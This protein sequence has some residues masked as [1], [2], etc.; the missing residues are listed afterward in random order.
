MKLP[1]CLLAGINRHLG[2]PFML[3]VFVM[4]FGTSSMASAAIISNIMATKHNLSA[5]GPG[6]VKAVSET[7]ICVFCH[8]PHGGDNTGGA[9]LWNRP[10]STASYNPYVSISMDAT[11]PPGAP[12][13]SS[14]LC[15]S[16]HDGTLAIGLVINLRGKGANILMHNT[17]PGGVMPDGS[18]AG[19]GYTSNL[20]IDL[21]NDHPISFTYDAT[22]AGND[23]ELQS[24]PFVVSAK[25]V[26]ANRAFGVKPT[27]PLENSQMQ[28]PTCHDPHFWDSN[29]NN[30]PLK[31]LRG[32][33]LQLAPPL[34]GNYIAASDI[35]CVACHDKD[36]GTQ[37]WSNSAHA[38]V[39]VATE[40][41][42]NSAA[43]LL[44][45]PHLTTVWQA[46]CVGCHDNHTVPGAKHLLREGTDSPSFPKSGGNSAMEQTCYQCHSLQGGNNLL[47]P[48]SPPN[49]VPDIQSDFASTIHMPIANQPEIHNTGGNFNDSI[50][51][52][53]GGI[54]TADTSAQCNT[55][56]SKCAKDL[57]ESEAL[58]GKPT[59][60]GLDSNRHAECTDCHNPHRATKNRLFSTNAATPDAAG[61][62]LHNI[63]SANPIAHNNIASGSLRGTFGVEPVYA[64]ADFGTPGIP[65]AFTVKRGDPGLSSFTDVSQTY[66]TREYQVCLKCHSN[67]AY[68]TPALLGYVG[69]TGT[70]T[71]GYNTY[72]NTAMELQAPSTHMG[73]PATT[74]DSGAYAPTYSANNYRSW[75]PVMDV[76][77][78]TV[79][80]RGNASPN[81]WRSPWNGSDTDGPSATLLVAG[82]A[83]GNQTMYCSDCHGSANSIINGVVPDGNG[84]VGAWTENGKPWGP[85][86]ST[87]NFL[88]KGPSNT[89][90]PVTTATDTLCF[91]C[92][93]ATQYADATGSPGSVLQSGFSAAG[94]DTMGA[95]MTNLHQRHAYYTST[96]GQAAYPSSVWP[97]GAVD[98]YR[99]T[100]CHT[101]TAHGW[102]NKDFLVNLN[103]VGPELNKAIN[104]TVGGALGG[105]LAPPS[106]TALSP[107]ANVPAGTVVP[108]AMAVVPNG[109]TNGPYYQ[110]ALLRI[111]GFKASGTWTKADC[112]TSGC[113]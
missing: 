103:D 43:D 18:V 106:S 107:G 91:R 68:D 21:S 57:M 49:T 88:L 29:P 52:G 34:G 89:N 81:L 54:A 100:M 15:L 24:P 72:L 4:L 26:V 19:T 71:N 104:S 37:I 96:A 11:Q 102:K 77:G 1:F 25:T 53:S 8:T 48:S 28:C 64:A 105:E 74:S 12:G 16:C 94:T 101:G 108:A 42:T 41:Y 30:P 66:V 38:N 97:A 6:P 55:P 9:P 87:Q 84:S 50:G 2:I 111:V 46:S 73:A 110:G 22:L 51:A 93:D 10:T 31:F 113:H 32:M 95:P 33:R 59:A 61:T 3:L 98:T 62:H 17:G 99:C 78:R 83:V 69:G 65:T 75:H 80:N 86:G 60:G 45:F 85:H 23:G 20:G 76:T 109:Y 90:I 47:N 40:E 79:A 58:L 63:D 27:F 92:H 70:T 82:G 56:G 13:A 35:M 39:N 5:S 36:K 44:E 112:S 67:Y 14:K 7:Q